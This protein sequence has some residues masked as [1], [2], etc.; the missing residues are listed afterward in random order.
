MRP[1]HLDLLLSP[2]NKLKGVGPK[3]EN[4]INKLG[5]NL[6]VHFLWHFPYRI[7][8]KK[9][10]ENIHDAPINQ[11][12]TIKIEV[13]KHYPSK[14]RR[15]PYRVSCLAN[16]IPIDIVYFNARH[17]VI[18][19]VLPLKSFKMI[20]GKLQF[21]KNKFQITH[22]ASVENISHIQLLRE[23]E[24][25]YSLTAGLNMKSFIK[26]SNQV[27]QL[28]PNPREWIDN[29]LLKKYN[30][31]SWKE[32]I[33][34]LHNPEIEDTYNEKNFFRRRLAFDELYAHQL[35]IC[36]IRTIDN[37]KKS[38]S[39]KN[40]NKLKKILIN[41]LEFKLTNSQSIVLNEIQ[42]DLES[43]KQMIRLLQGDVGSG[44][45]IVALISM[46]T[47]IESGYQATLMAPTSILAYQHFENI[48]KL[49]Q[50]LPIQID[51]L[52]GK[53]KGKS[54]IEKLE[55]IKDGST[56]IIIGTHALIQEGV[57]FKKLGFSVID[58][59]HRFG[60]YQRMA[61]NYKGFRPSILVMSATPI[62]RTLTLAAYGDMDESRLID[63]PIG[64]KPIKTSS[65]TL[66]KEKN[67][68]ER[69]KAKINN[70]ND[71]FFWVC[72]LIEES[73]ELDLKAATDR[74]N[75]LNKIFKNKVMLIHGQLS[76]KEKESTMEKF[77]N[78]DYRILVATTVIEVGIDIKSATTIIIEHAERFGLAQ[79]HQLRGRVGRNNEE[80]YCILLHKENLNDTAKKRISI[81]I[82]TNDG[83]LIAEEDLKIRGPGEIL[84]K[85][86]SGLPSFN[87]ADLSYDGDLLEEA[88]FYADNI[89]TED[90]RLE[91]NGNKNLKDLL[92]IQERDTAIRTLSA[93]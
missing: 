1:A 46:L 47:V 2:I 34:K 12:V 56:Q 69:I 78:E 53:D 19:S 93:G 60:V 48:S 67:L 64:R 68:I 76:E 88:K 44:K 10:Y 50:N 7:I 28:L 77:K 65:L 84:G 32:A 87:V 52:T 21:F 91:R 75:S 43:N 72:P 82:E 57:N 31:V 29:R 4:I 30:F 49:L 37:K 63:K 18:R 90:P 92:Y 24:P 62:P 3:L 83:F 86:Q 35:A 22:P 54:R 11:L 58:E 80:S 71:K 51:I 70:S 42:N 55:K 73:Q 17:P 6:N 26:L 16:E 38:T 20:S 36:I 85:R 59:Q 81:M 79:L 8:E 61:F 39:F 5:I 14:F 33:E 27:L 89:I 15:Q 13:I 41:S 66:K 23:K 74:Y 25:V 45:T 40:K 9:Y